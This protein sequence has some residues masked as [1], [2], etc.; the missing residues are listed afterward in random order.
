[1]KNVRVVAM[2]TTHRMRYGLRGLRFC[3]LIRVSYMVF[4]LK[5]GIVQN[6]ELLVM[7]RSRSGV[8]RRRG[9]MSVNVARGA[10]TA[11]RVNGLG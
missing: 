7:R 9:S 2:T 1:M 8:I 6:N 4:S 11:S 10:S 5:K 3:M